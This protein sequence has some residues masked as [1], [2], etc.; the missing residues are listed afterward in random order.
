VMTLMV[1][2]S[3]RYLINFDLWH[4]LYWGCAFGINYAATFGM[5]T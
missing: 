3:L 1:A 2:A 4:A 5:K